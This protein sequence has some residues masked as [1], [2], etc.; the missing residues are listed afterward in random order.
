M[1]KQIPNIPLNRPKYA[2]GKE[3]SVFAFAKKAILGQLAEDTKPLFRLGNLVS[4]VTN[5]MVR[6]I[7]FCRQC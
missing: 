5:W 4:L 3:I 1:V 6:S 2:T 7:P